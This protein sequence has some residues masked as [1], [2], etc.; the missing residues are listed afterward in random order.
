MVV[1]QDAYGQRSQLVLSVIPLIPG[2]IRH[3]VLGGDQTKP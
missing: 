3:P 1:S 2:L